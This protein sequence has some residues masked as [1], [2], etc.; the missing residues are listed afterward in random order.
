[1]PKTSDRGG[2]TGGGLVDNA[3]DFS[4]STG[5]T[6]NNGSGAGLAFIGTGYAQVYIPALSAPTPFDV[7]N[8]FAGPRVERNL[9]TEVDCTDYQVWVRL[10]SGGN[11]DVTGR[12]NLYVATADDS[13]M[14]SDTVYSNMNSLETVDLGIT[15]VPIRAAGPGFLMTASG[16]CWLGISVKRSTVTF[17]YANTISSLT[18]PTQSDI[19][20]YSTY[21]LSTAIGG[22][23]FGIRQLCKVGVSV[24]TYGGVNATMQSLIIDRMVIKGTPIT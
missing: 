1:M 14:L 6:Q 11:F 12:A 7:I 20:L 8:G 17:M 22:P 10:F 9:A 19:L 2:S 5:F 18:F 23:P 15:G 4:S 16:G 24:A 3:Y 21:N 13:V